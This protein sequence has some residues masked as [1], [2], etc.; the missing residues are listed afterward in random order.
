MLFDRK[1]LLRMFA[2]AMLL[3]G[4]LIPVANA[5]D[6]GAS[7]PVD[8]ALWQ[9]ECGS[10]HVA[11]PPRL[12]SAESW[13]AIMSGLRKHF[14]T[15]ASLKLD[16]ARKIYAFLEKNAGSKKYEASTNPLLRITETHWFKQVHS[17]V[18]ER[19]WKRPRIKSAA[20][21]VACHIQAEKGIYDGR[22]SIIPK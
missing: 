7:A 3:T 13:R 16:V 19:T 21:C 14:G 20:N 11:F 18:S 10:C 12:H 5:E 2:V 1:T 17:E 6:Q 15:D 22:N 4:G 8:N 9:A